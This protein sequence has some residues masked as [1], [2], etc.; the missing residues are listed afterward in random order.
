LT[1]QVI[2]RFVSVGMRF[3]IANI[4]KIIITPTTVRRIK[5][6]LFAIQKL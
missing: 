3:G 6:F 1:H 2:V 5:D 4:L